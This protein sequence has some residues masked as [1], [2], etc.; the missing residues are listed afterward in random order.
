MGAAVFRGSED[1]VLA[2]FVGA[3]HAFGLS[4]VIR[5]TADNPFVDPDG[6]SRLVRLL[7]H[8]RADHVVER[9]LPI[10]AAVEL[11]SRRGARALT[12]AHHATVTTAST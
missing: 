8:V 11:V 12:R 9:G 5:A 3:A 2:R 7:A 1:D 4:T 10:G 6:P